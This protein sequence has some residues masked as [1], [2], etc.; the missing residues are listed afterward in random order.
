MYFYIK[1]SVL[2][3]LLL[4]L[5]LSFYSGI[6]AESQ[7]KPPGVGVEEKLGQKIPLALSLQNEEGKTV[8]LE[9]FL[10][11]RRPLIIVP[12]YY[13]CVR[14]CSFIFQGVQ[15]AAD[16]AFSNGIKLGRDYRIL[17]ISINPQDTPQT[18]HQKGEEIRN[19]FQNTKVRA[20]DW[21]FL[22]GKGEAVPSLM[23]ALGYS[24]RWDSNG[25]EDISHSAAIVLVS[26][27]GRITRYLYGV[28]F[29]QRE[30]RLSLV[31]STRGK[32]GSAAE[33]ILLFCFRY[34][35]IEGKYTP[36]AWAFV[37]I[38]GILT[39]CFLLAL[40]FS[41]LD[42]EVKNKKGNFTLLSFSC[43]NILCTVRLENIDLLKSIPF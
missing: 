33:K 10:K 8:L 16:A 11:G 24:Y 31:E 4:F 36:F 35:P 34:D 20:Q 13:T 29:P 18:A 30:F 40:W 2:F 25:G 37:R 38:G 12:S 42:L 5:G 6:G 23:K 19:A 3:V 21:H 22:T 26:P 27:E 15:K 9:N 32:I 28:Q 7:R 43:I 17:S 1:N 41:C 39:L 14:L